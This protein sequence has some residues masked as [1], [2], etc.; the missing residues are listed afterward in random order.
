MSDCEL[1]ELNISALLDGELEGKALLP[2]LDHLTHC[3]HCR[4]FYDDARELETLVARLSAPAPLVAPV[5]DRERQVAGPAVQQ[6]AG[7][8]AWEA[9]G[10]AVWHRIFQPPTWAWAAAAFLLVAIGFTGG[11]LANR[12]PQVSA[13]L[14]GTPVEITL[15]E[16]RGAMDQERFVALTLELLRADPGY[17]REMLHVLQQVQPTEQNEE[18][19]PL[20]ASS[21]SREDHLRD[22]SAEGLGETRRPSEESGQAIE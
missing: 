18:L 7:P 14:P 8:A 3:P 4:A 2:L 6:A 9:A 12:L 10:P 20:F 19:V 1:H 16:N 13:P 17:H 15:G 5:D 11:H 21:L 22:D